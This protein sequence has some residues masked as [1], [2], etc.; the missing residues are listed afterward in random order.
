METTKAKSL[1]QLAFAALV[2]LA[3]CIV[4][5]DVQTT[6]ECYKFSRVSHKLHSRKK[7]IGAGSK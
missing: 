6:L 7:A 5:D 2:G 1:V 3:S 4:L